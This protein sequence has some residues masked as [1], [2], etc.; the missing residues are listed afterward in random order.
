MVSRV[1][2]DAP[3]LRMGNVI[4]DL[5]GKN[6]KTSNDSVFNSA[7]GLQDTNLARIKAAQDYL[8]N[9]DQ[10]FVVANISRVLTNHSLKLA[11]DSAISH[12]TARGWKGRHGEGLHVAVICTKSEVCLI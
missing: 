8:S 11:L 2:I 4:A 5:P 7:L 12:H 9:C 10:V 3:I 1:F 6:D